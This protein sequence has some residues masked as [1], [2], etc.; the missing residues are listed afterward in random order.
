MAIFNNLGWKV[1]ALIVAFGLWLMVM[2][3]NAIEISKDVELDI[4]LPPGLIIANDVPSKVSLRLQGSKLFLRTLANN[5]DRVQVDLTRAKV[6][7]TYFRIERENLR[8]PIGIKILSISPTTINPILEPILIR[9]VPVNVVAKNK[10]PNGYRLLKLEANPAQVKIRGP[11][12]Q[13]EKINFINATPVDLSDVPAALR[14]ELN[15]SNPAPQVVY[16]EDLDPKIL[17][18]VEPTGSNFRVAGVPVIVDSNKKTSLNIDKVALYVNCPPG[19]I[20]SFTPDKVRATVSVGDA[21][22]GIYLREVKVELPPGVR[23]V[24][25]VPDRL[26]VQV[27]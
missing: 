3:T 11:R 9:T 15:L 13:V 19:L 12:S 2:S 4:D 5:L 8:L 22:P 7:P 21:G 1:L 14:W 18:E 17:V 10:L 26:Q 24:R 27:E 6:G 23:L 20:Q 25:V 16:D